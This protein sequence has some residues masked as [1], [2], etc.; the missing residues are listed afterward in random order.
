[1]IIT[2]WGTFHQMDYLTVNNGQK[3]GGQKE[4]S[5]NSQI[6]DLD[7]ISIKTPIMKHEKDMS[8]YGNIWF[9]F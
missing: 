6:K 9:E 2:V 7:V 1:M 8:C 3:Q 5:D 4:L